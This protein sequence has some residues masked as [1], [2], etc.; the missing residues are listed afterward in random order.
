MQHLFAN[1]Y[2]GN[3]LYC[4][5]KKKIYICYHLTP[6]IIIIIILLLLLYDADDD[7][8]TGINL[9]MEDHIERTWFTVHKM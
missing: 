6:I 8:L 2:I 9:S 1:T 7:K 3:R 5:I 4:L